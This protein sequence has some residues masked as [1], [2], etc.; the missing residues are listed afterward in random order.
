LP[1]I[2]YRPPKYSPAFAEDFIELLSTISTEFDCFAIAG[3][4]N[5]HIDN[6]QN[7]MTK[8]IKTFLKTFV[9]KQA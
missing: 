4:F 6:A 7:N 1:I 3:D 5:I 8:E 2:I 9:S